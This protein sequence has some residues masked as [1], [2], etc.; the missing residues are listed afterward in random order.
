MIKLLKHYA[1]DIIISSALILPAYL[2]G[3]YCGHRERTMQDCSRLCKDLAN[4]R[5]RYYR[6]SNDLKDTMTEMLRYK[7]ELQKKEGGK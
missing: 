6:V 4:L 5:E 2:I 3:Y 1:A 7:L